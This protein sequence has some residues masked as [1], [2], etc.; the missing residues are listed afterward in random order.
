MKKLGLTGLALIAALGTAA[1]PSIVGCEGDTIIIGGNSDT[2]SSDVYQGPFAE[3]KG[4]CHKFFSYCGSTSVH[5]ID[6][7]AYRSG[8]FFS[9]EEC[10]T[11]CNEDVAPTGQSQY[12]IMA[13]CLLKYECCP[14]SYDS[15]ICGEKTEDFLDCVFSFDY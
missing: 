7:M 4:F 2:H 9:V 10:L 6:D 12:C 14:W 13:A 15:G 5:R 8:G 3:F 1:L 11:E